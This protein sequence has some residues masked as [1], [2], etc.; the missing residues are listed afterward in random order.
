M[1]ENDPRLIVTLETYGTTAEKAWNRSQNQNR[2][3]PASESVAD[4]S[5]RENTPAVNQTA[6]QIQLIFDDKSKNLEKNFVFGSD[7]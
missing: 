6:S 3:L 5:N 1:D 7:P 4:I 2:C